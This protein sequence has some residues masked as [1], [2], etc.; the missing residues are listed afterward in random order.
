MAEDF[1]PD[2]EQDPIMLARS[3]MDHTNQMLTLNQPPQNGMWARNTPGMQA[4]V[5][6]A[7]GLPRQNEETGDQ[8]RARQIAQAGMAVDPMATD[9]GWTDKLKNFAIENVALPVLDTATFVLSPF[10]ATSNMITAPL[11]HDYETPFMEDPYGFVVEAL[12]ASGQG[13]SEALLPTYGEPGPDYGYQI[14]N[15]LFGDAPELLKSSLGLT[16]NV[17]LDPLV[18]TGVGY[19]KVLRRGVQA[20]RAAMR[21][22]QLTNWG[23]MEKSVLEF[24][25]VKPIEDFAAAGEQAVRAATQEKH[26][27]MMTLAK[28]TDAGDKEAAKELGAM[29][30]AD[31]AQAVIKNT[32]D[33]AKSDYHDTLHDAYGED[34]ATD[35]DALVEYY[36]QRWRDEEFNRIAAEQQAE[37]AAKGIAG[38]DLAARMQS[39]YEDITDRVNRTP[40]PDDVKSRIDEEVKRVRPLSERIDEAIGDIAVSSKGQSYNKLL[41]L[42]QKEYGMNTA[43]IFDSFYKRKQEVFTK[44]AVD[45]RLQTLRGELKRQGLRGTTLE[46]RLSNAAKVIGP[47][48]ARESIPDKVLSGFAK[49]SLNEAKIAFAE[50][51]N[52]FVAKVVDITTRDGNVQLARLLAQN[53]IHKVLSLNLN[54]IAPEDYNDALRILMDEYGKLYQHLQKRHAYTFEGVVNK[55]TQVSL[56]TLLGTDFDTRGWTAQEFFAAQST[57]NL[58]AD[59]VSRLKSAVLQTAEPHYSVAFNRAIDMFTSLVSQ[60]SKGKQAWSEAGAAQRWFAE[61]QE[62]GSRLREYSRDIKSAKDAVEK[63]AG[64]QDIGADKKAYLVAEKLDQM[65]KLGFGQRFVRA[66][67]KDGVAIT[68][69]LFESYVNSILSAISQHVKN[70]VST[71]VFT[72]VQ[73][74]EM[75]LDAPFESGK[76]IQEF[77]HAM[78]GIAEGMRDALYFLLHSATDN[79]IAESVLP[80]HSLDAI[81]TRMRGIE[82]TY[83]PMYINNT[84]YGE[85]ARYA[86]EAAKLI[87]R[88][89]ISS[90]NFG[91]QPD[92]I[93]GQIVDA[94]GWFIR[95]PGTAFRLEDAG[96]KFMGYRIGTRIAAFRKAVSEGI[97]DK[98][99]LTKYVKEATSNPTKKLAE[100]GMRMADYVTF[101]TQLQGWQRQS[102][103]L[104]Q[105][106]F[107][108]WFFPFY[109]TPMNL[110]TRTAERL[111][112]SGH[113]LALLRL[114]KQDV[115]GFQQAA[116]RSTFGMLVMMGANALLDEERIV[117]DYEFNSPYGQKMRAL[118]IPPNSIRAGDNWISYE[119]VDFIRGTLGLIANY[120]QAMAA[121]DLKDPNDID[122]ADTITAALIVPFSKMATNKQ[123]LTEFGRLQYYYES[124]QELDNSFV[125]VA[126][127]EA[128]RVASGTI[129]YSA[130]L[131]DF[132]RSF[133]DD[134]FRIA[135]DFISRIKSGLPGHSKDLPPYRD[136]WGD[137]LIASQ[138]F[139][140]DLHHRLFDFVNP[141]KVQRASDDPVVK[142][143]MR[144]PIQFP[145]MRRTLEGV[146]LSKTERSMVQFYT[147]KGVVAGQ[148][149]KSTLRTMMYRPEYVRATDAGKASILLSVYNRFVTNAM[150]KVLDDSRTQDPSPESLFN[151]VMR[152]RQWQL[153]QLDPSI[154]MR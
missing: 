81:R 135:D 120:R 150:R 89:A 114:Y 95:V 103:L 137:P 143:L 52:A 127:K 53:Q 75:M 12:E 118:G 146:E 106:R 109:K 85:D 15:K 107:F 18:W 86:H 76:P 84:A 102:Q 72:L 130:F 13:V 138:A 20:S 142:E 31:D 40:I 62:Q 73:P 57:T 65:E 49:T 50:G 46:T 24:L 41:N 121:L 149:L 140:P 129:P 82:K 67:G 36:N 128:G 122:L 125:D 141:E 97:T 68:D 119:S 105:N 154:Q 33:R 14:A 54:N 93:S 133:L 83:P 60:V 22:G 45:A 151:K 5:P 123:W 147:G 58:L 108:R 7:Q 16:F 6:I 92:K 132:N 113:A 39:Q 1:V 17:V 21:T 152:K 144:V 32:E 27:K 44:M 111:P 131:R 124:I 126:S 71:T 66:L 47:R 48:I 11:A 77:G 104:L 134:E 37:L 110:I 29:F 23:L 61:L 9:Q 56:E 42:I 87:S 3:I 4:T 148:D 112:V 51:G 94:A 59:E 117:G 64:I 10:S 99:E 8:Y 98:R 2:F 101:Q 43:K 26:A 63:V 79:T 74:F 80:E 78:A 100:E 88:K 91:L 116:T 69:V 38:D 96:F 34:F 35:K 30:E 25:A 139:G 28:Q 55:S 90:T 70:V 19:A 136:M 153:M 145:P 115:R